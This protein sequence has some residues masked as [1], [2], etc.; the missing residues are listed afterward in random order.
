MCKWNFD[1]WHLVQYLEI[2]QVSELRKS[3]NDVVMGVESLNNLAVNSRFVL[4]FGC[5]IM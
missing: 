3:M 5:V 1:F 4:G 2:Y